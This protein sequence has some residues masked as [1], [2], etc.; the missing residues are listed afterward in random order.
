MIFFS[1]SMEACLLRLTAN[2]RSAGIGTALI[3]AV[4][5]GCGNKSLCLLEEITPGVFVFRLN[6]HFLIGVIP[7]VH[8]VIDP[9]IVFQI[10][11]M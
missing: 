2:A 8:H 10:I 9:N 1:I 7:I 4:G 5:I 3:T 6:M 11:K